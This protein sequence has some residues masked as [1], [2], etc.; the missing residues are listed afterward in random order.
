M[1][2]NEDNVVRQWIE[3]HSKIGVSRFIINIMVSQRI[4]DITVLKGQVI[5]VNY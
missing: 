2:K 5:Y 3:F 1:V 4:R